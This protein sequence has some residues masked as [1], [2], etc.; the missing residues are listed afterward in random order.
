M[1]S[2]IYSP[3]DSAKATLYCVAEGA[4]YLSAPCGEAILTGKTVLDL[5]FL[6]VG[7]P[8]ASIEL[9]LV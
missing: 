3:V 5:T 6:A 7:A 1:C 8:I 4:A 2:L 9:P